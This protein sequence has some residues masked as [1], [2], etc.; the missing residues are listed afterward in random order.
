MRQCRITHN[1]IGKLHGGTSSVQ[2][3][4]KSEKE[5]TVYNSGSFGYV[6]DFQQFDTDRGGFLRFERKIYGIAVQAYF[7]FWGFGGTGYP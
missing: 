2:M 1:T 3:G 5:N 4:E 6:M 7:V